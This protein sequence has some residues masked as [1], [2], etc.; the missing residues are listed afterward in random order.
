MKHLKQRS[1]FTV[2]NRLLSQPCVVKMAWKAKMKGVQSLYCTWD[3]VG[4]DHG[5][6]ISQN[7][8]RIILEWKTCSQTNC[9]SVYNQYQFLNKVDLSHCSTDNFLLVISKRPHGAVTAVC[10]CSLCRFVEVRSFFFFP[11]WALKLKARRRTHSTVSHK[12]LSITA[13]LTWCKWREEDKEE[14]ALTEL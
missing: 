7:C 12:T 9:T 2:R 14:K 6:H 4:Y 10:A 11:S 8:C 13:P 1:H 3:H 5:C